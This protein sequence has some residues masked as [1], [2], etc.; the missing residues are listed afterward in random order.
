MS[1]DEFESQQRWHYIVICL[2]PYT[3]QIT[4]TDAHLDPRLSIEIVLLRMDFIEIS[5]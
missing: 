5:I 3:L 2:S 1:L 4:R